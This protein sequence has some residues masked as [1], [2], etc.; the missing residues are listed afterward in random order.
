M[1]HNTINLQI[2]D[3]KEKVRNELELIKQEL[4]ISYNTDAVVH[5]I[6]NYR[7]LVRQLDFYKKDFSDT[8]K[9]RF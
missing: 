5:L 3:S 9:A 7:K 4:D 6:L 2:K 8:I 1:A